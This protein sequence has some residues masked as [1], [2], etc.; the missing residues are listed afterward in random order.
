M[1]VE[2][3]AVRIPFFG[4]AIDG[5]DVTLVGGT[6]LCILLVMLMFSL[7]RELS[8]LTISFRRADSTN[9]LPEFYDL[10]AMQQIYNAPVTHIS[11]KTGL[12]RFVMTA[13]VM[14]PAVIMSISI[15]I[16]I[17]TID[18]GHLMNRSRTDW[19]LFWE[20]VLCAASWAIGLWAVGV[21]RRMHHL[22]DE[23]W[24]KRAT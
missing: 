24:A 15:G 21:C 11:Q 2:D 14:L 3:S 1:D 10:F 16:D 5:P 12:Y 6:V 4:I 19:W 8:N 22:F 20:S 18:V 23:Q 7:N 17:A 9:Q 13:I